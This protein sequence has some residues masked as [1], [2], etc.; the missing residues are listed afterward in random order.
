MRTQYYHILNKQGGGYTIKGEGHAIVVGDL[1]VVRN[2]SKGFVSLASAEKF[3]KP[4]HKGIM[5]ISD[6][7]VSFSNMSLERE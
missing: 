2:H 5:K 1:S 6:K 3:M 7:G 4:H